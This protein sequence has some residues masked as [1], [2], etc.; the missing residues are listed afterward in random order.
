MS[1]F[2]F[3]FV[4]LYV[5][6]FIV[7]IISGCSSENSH[8]NMN[9]TIQP[10]SDTDSNYELRI[11]TY[12]L[13]EQLGGFQALHKYQFYLSDT[14][15]L[16]RVYSHMKSTTEGD[17]KEVEKEHSIIFSPSTPGV[18]RSENSGIL[19]IYFDEG[20]DAYLPFTCIAGIGFCVSDYGGW[21]K[22]AYWKFNRTKTIS[23]IVRVDKSSLRI[24]ETAKGRVLEQ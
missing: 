4:K 15:R 11:V 1:T 18:Y 9:G 10:K 21:Y 22:S 23:L 3:S 8:S 14:L 13:I 12:K 20:E 5:F 16:T 7:I 6:Y 2:N 17:V 24:N 19:N